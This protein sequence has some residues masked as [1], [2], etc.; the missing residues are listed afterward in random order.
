MATANASPRAQRS[1]I[2]TSPLYELAGFCLEV[3]C[4]AEGWRRDQMFAVSELASIY[5]RDRT[6]SDVLRRMRCSVLNMR[7]RPRPVAGESPA[8]GTSNLRCRRPFAEERGC[9]QPAIS[10]APD[11][12]VL[13]SWR[14]K[15]AYFILSFEDGATIDWLGS[16]PARSS[17]TVEAKSA[18]LHGDALTLTIAGTVQRQP[19][20]LG[21][22]RST[23]RRS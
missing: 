15:N 3:D 2:F 6:V 1:A 12:E 10:P 11:G 20:P 7:V 21:V 9:A 4:W 23:V 5:G 17:G 14:S 8:L 13:V 18:E 19:L 22:E 16:L